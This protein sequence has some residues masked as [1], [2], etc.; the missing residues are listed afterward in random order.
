MN[1]RNTNPLCE[2]E[3]GPMNRRN[4]NSLYEF[5]LVD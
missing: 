1:R 4:I 2:F 5:E 3:L